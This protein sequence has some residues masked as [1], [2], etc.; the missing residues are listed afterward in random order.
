MRSPLSWTRSSPPSFLRVV[1]SQ[2]LWTNAELSPILAYL[3]LVRNGRTRTG[4]ARFLSDCVLWCHYP[5]AYPP[6]AEP[7]GHFVPGLFSAELLT[8]ARELVIE[9]AG[10]LGDSV[11][12]TVLREISRTYLESVGSTLAKRLERR[13]T[14]WCDR[15]VREP[16]RPRRVR[17]DC[18]SLAAKRSEVLGSH[19]GRVED[20]DDVLNYVC[21]VKDGGA[22]KEKRKPGL[23]EVK[24]RP[25]PGGSP[26]A[27]VEDPVPEG[28]RVICSVEDFEATSVGFIDSLPAELLID[29]GA[30]ASLVDSRVLEKLGLAK[31]PLRPYHG[32]LNGVSGHPLHIRGEI[33]LPL[34]IGTLEKLRTFAVVDRLHVHTL[35]G[36]DALKAFR[37]VIDM[38]ESVMTLKE[39]GETFRLGAS[40]V[41]EMYVSRINST[42]RLCSGGQALVVANLME[43]PDNRRSM[44]RLRRR[45]G[46]PEGYG[47]RCCDGRAEDGVPAYSASVPERVWY[48]GCRL[49][50]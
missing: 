4:P 35:L 19:T 44:Q 22:E 17:F 24:D 28:K 15:P 42:V 11:R 30:I 14:C 47:S 45:H 10:V 20:P 1:W 39:T 8:R 25:T 21:F 40:L 2:Q 29:I 34:R 5:E 43:R 38:E 31:A 18:S 33:E 32:S 48:A 41:E 50:D 27:D 37:A 9:R 23:V 36:T 16:I 12:Q 13:R 7:R 26:N 49:R 6:E 46:D 3:V